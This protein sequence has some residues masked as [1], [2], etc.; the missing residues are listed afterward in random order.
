[1]G[2]ALPA[3][4]CAVLVS[5]GGAHAPANAAADDPAA[6]NVRADLAAG[7]A[8]ALTTWCR[9]GAGCCPTSSLRGTG[10][11]FVSSCS[12]GA[13]VTVWLCEWLLVCVRVGAALPCHVL[14]AVELDVHCHLHG[15]GLRLAFL[16]L[17]A[18]G[19]GWQRGQRRPPLDCC[20]RR[21]PGPDHRPRGFS[22]QRGRAILQ[23]F[24]SR[25]ERCW[26]LH[27]PKSSGHRTW[28]QRLAFSC[29]C[30]R[31]DRPSEHSGT[32]VR[33]RTLYTAPCPDLRSWS[34]TSSISVVQSELGEAQHQA[35]SSRAAPAYPSAYLCQ[36][37][38]WPYEGLA[39]TA[40]RR[41][42][43]LGH[44]I[45][46]LPGKEHC[47]SAP[48]IEGMQSGLLSS[49]RCGPCSRAAPCHRG[50]QEGGCHSS[51][52]SRGCAWGLAATKFRTTPCR[53][54]ASSRP[55]HTCT[56]CSGEGELD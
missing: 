19:N 32:F 51:A 39:G 8:R 1:M 11:V 56:P 42:C 54:A 7:H 36:P 18:Q 4:V 55:R 15:H 13:P 21:L 9:L 22:R 41:V 45:H 50:S 6:S 10:L 49:A 25:T 37:S 24:A 23:T 2:K 16:Q 27:L 38:H 47:G 26:V 29:S 28:K 34:A 17:L 12:A 44:R 5:A 48:G 20:G 43:A 52:P 35:A 53:R 14:R 46:R 30:R 40:G 33:R 31:R 3:K